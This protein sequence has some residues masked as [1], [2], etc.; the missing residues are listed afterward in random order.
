M[1]IVQATNQILGSPVNR[2][3][4]MANWASRGL[5]TKENLTFRERVEGWLDHVKF[6]LTLGIMGVAFWWNRVRQV[7][8]GSEVGWEDLVQRQLKSVAKANFGIDLKDDALMS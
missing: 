3:T 4:L 5:I 2:P 7:V 6:R 1:R 8:F